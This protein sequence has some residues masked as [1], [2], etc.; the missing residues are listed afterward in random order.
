MKL[1]CWYPLEAR[2]NRLSTA[3]LL[4]R[5]V[6]GVGMALHGWPK[7]QNMTTWMGEGSSA[8][9]VVFIALAAIAEFIGGLALALGVFT[10]VATFLMGCT[11]LVA[12]SFH[13]KRGDPWIS[14]GGPAWELAGLYLV[15]SVMFF[16][17]GPGRFSLDALITRRFRKS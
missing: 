1:D 15:L 7:F 16:L 2:D 12:A 17:V 4:V 10:P 9:P 5:V 11:M 6:V 13:I 3:L 8:V 14:K